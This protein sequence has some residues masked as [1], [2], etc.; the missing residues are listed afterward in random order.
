M[1]IEPCA[2]KSIGGGSMNSSLRRELNSCINELN[3]IV[4]ELNSVSNEISSCISGMN[5]RKYTQALENSATK[6]KKAANKLSRIK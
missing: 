1:G 6:Y 2:T 5:T 3:S 4:R